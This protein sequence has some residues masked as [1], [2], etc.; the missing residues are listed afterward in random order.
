MKSKM[1]TVFLALVFSI[2]LCAC[3][4][5]GSLNLD[6][7]SSS[8]GTKTTDTN[9]SSGNSNDS[10]DTS[11]KEESS[12][13]EAYQKILQNEGSFFCSDDKTDVSL[14]EFLKNNSKN[15]NTL[16]VTNFTV[17]DMEG[18]GIMEAV[19]E[20]SYGEDP[21]SFEVLHY[22]NGTVYGYN[23]A[24][25]GLEQLKEDGTFHYTN[26][27]TDVGVQKVTKF[28]S[29]IYATETLGYSQLDTSDTSDTDSEETK[30]L[31]F[32]ENKSVKKEL[33]DS[34]MKEQNEKED[35]PW[36]EFTQENI[37]TEL[38]LVSQ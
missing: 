33:F 4:N 21:Y 5:Q 9:I 27:T 6:D 26:S 32:L 29:D 31:Y 1:V 38:G 2:S 24:Y 37:E 34:F 19:L 23:I 20:L 17:L 10:S 36:Y 7:N 8:A 25:R 15:K 18:D 16:E 12:A 28:E 3:T 22:D 13:K 30:I 14:H 11:S 35:A